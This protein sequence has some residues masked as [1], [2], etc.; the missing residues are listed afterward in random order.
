MFICWLEFW[1]VYIGVSCHSVTLIDI[2][3]VQ[4]FLSH[5]APGALAMTTA[6]VSMVPQIFSKFWA[7]RWLWRSWPSTGAT[8]SQQL[9]G[10]GCTVPT[11]RI[12]R[13]PDLICNLVEDVELF[14]EIDICCSHL[15]W[16]ATLTHVLDECWDHMWIDLTDVYLLVRVLVGLYWSRLPQYHFELISLLFNPSC[17]TLRQVLWQKQQRRRWRSRSFPSSGQSDD[18]GDVGLSQLRPDPSSCVAAAARCRLAE[19]ED[20]QIWFVTWQTTWSCFLKLIFVVPT[21]FGG[22]R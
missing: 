18:F 11:G 14:P 21:C 17:L 16:W 8:R 19:S 7:K 15:L 9:R 20:C 22:R 3:V 4:S 13:L 5:L 6:K 1:W 12:W 10:S 2:F